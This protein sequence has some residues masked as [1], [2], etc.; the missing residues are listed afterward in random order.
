MQKSLLTFN[1]HL[2][3]GLV[4]LIGSFVLSESCFGLHNTDEGCQ[5]IPPTRRHAVRAE[6]EDGFM[7]CGRPHNSQQS[8]GDE[9]GDE[10][11]ILISCCGVMGFIQLFIGAGLSIWSP[12]ARQRAVGE[13]LA[14]I[15]GSIGVGAIISNLCRV[16]WCWTEDDLTNEED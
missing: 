12:D 1:K 8:C 9:C 10:A 11:G 3:I 13:T 15:G 16:V 2:L 5:T 4:Y 14:W 7:C 6:P